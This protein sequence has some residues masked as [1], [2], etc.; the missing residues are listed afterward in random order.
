[1]IDWITLFFYLKKNNYICVDYHKLGEVACRTLNQVW[2]RLYMVDGTIL[3]RT[4]LASM[5]VDTVFSEN[6]IK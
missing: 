3:A 6:K 1:M 2:L 4:I 5:H